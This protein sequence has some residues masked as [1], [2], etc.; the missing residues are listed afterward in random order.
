MH[1]FKF[2]SQIM[3]VDDIPNANNPPTPGSSPKKSP[4]SPAASPSSAP[5]KVNTSITSASSAPAPAV[6][7]SSRTS[8]TPSATTPSVT[9]ATA[10]PASSSTRA[11]AR[12]GE[13]TAGQAQAGSSSVG[14]PP[15]G[16]GKKTRIERERDLLLNTPRVR[17]LQTRLTALDA[18]FAKAKLPQFQKEV[19]AV[20]EWVKVRG[21]VSGGP[22]GGGG[23]ESTLRADEF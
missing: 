6:P 21:D 5:H 23:V 16:G 22:S 11:P 4:A 17:V 9:S 1:F 13:Q 14:P 15:S 7:N 12:S 19:H 3:A 18:A 10:T 2:N 20:I 8:G